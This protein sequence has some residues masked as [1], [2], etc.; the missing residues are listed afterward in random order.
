MNI[1]DGMTKKESLIKQA[2]D[3]PKVRLRGGFSDRNGIKPENAEIQLTNFDRRTRIQ[4]LNMINSL[5]NYVYNYYSKE[6]LEKFILQDI[7]D[8]IMFILSNVYSEVV[9]PRKCY[10][11]DKFMEYRIYQTVQNAEYDDVLTL[12]EAIIQYWDKYLKEKGDRYY[13][14]FWGNYNEP[15]LFEAVNSF[16]EREYVGYRFVDE[17]IVPISD[18]Y[19]ISAINDALST[20]YKS[21]RE[22]ISKANKLLA[23]RENPDYENSIKES[24][25][26]VEAICV[27]I[28]GAKGGE[29]T[30]GKML[31]KMEDHG[32]VI[33]GALKD[34]FDKLYGYTSSAKGIRHAGKMDG[35]SSTFEEAKFMLVACC[36]F[37]NY[38]TSLSSK[39]VKK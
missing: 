5:C 25:S 23:D 20:G 7:Q 26:A 14:K 16:F 32:V 24:I 11:F 17:R 2:M 9:D 29:A 13:N 27:I 10:D 39:C 8:F 1:K 21:V 4:L 19:E 33:H 3:I 34:A 36:A 28:T 35:P 15:S 31:K 18:K 37:I 12:I 30:L 22:H 6:R 38:I